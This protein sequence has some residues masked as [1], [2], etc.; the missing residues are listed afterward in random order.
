MITEPRTG[1]QRTPLQGFETLYI[2][3][4]EPAIVR[5]ALVGIALVGIALVG[6]TGSKSRLCATA[7][8][9]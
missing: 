9:I 3:G 4:A 7:K 2:G 8:K 6:M 5:R 1:G